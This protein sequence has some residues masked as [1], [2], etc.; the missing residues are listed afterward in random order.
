MTL[1]HSFCNKH[2]AVLELQPTW[3]TVGVWLPHHLR[4]QLLPPPSLQG[5]R[6]VPPISGLALGPWVGERSVASGTSSMPFSTKGPNL[7]SKPFY[8][9]EP[10]FLF[11]VYCWEIVSEV[12]DLC[13]KHVVRQDQEQKPDTLCSGAKGQGLKVDSH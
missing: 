3:T 2:P 5:V 10:V 1:S 13:E 9:E 6:M 12:K 7:N 11:I 4:I 8:K